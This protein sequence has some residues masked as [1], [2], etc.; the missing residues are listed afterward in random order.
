MAAPPLQTTARKDSSVVEIEA[1]RSKTSKLRALTNQ[2]SETV[3]TQNEMIDDMN[4][5]MSTANDLVAKIRHNLKI[6]L[7]TTKRRTCWLSAGGIA[8]IFFI[9]YLI[10]R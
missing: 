8:L 3:D 10:I 1:L 4:K 6:A 9:C 5:D 7:H 2:L